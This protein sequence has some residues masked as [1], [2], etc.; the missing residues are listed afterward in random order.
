MNYSDQIAMIVLILSGLY[1]GINAVTNKNY[2]IEV[3]AKTLPNK[4][5]IL[6]RI[7]YI[8]CGLASVYLLVFSSSYTFLP[9][10]NKTVLPPSLLLLSEQAN[11]NAKIRVHAPGAI[12]VAYWA[13]QQD[14]KKIIDDP[15]KAYGT[16][17]NVGVAAV[18]DEYALLKLKCPSKYKVGKTKVELP[19]HVHYRMIYANGVLSEVKTVSVEKNCAK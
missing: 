14:V 6:L 3:L 16:Y 9:F 11:T 5:R 13:A 18:K 12:K 2:F 10:L 8:I 7:I 15:Y 19:R 17:E 1:L 4:H